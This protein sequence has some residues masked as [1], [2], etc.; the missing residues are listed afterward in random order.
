MPDAPGTLSFNVN[1]TGPGVFTAPAAITAPSVPTAPSVSVLTPVMV[2]FSGTGFGQPGGANFQIWGALVA[3]N[4]QTYNVTS[5]PLNITIG[6][7]ASWTGN[8]Q[9]T[10]TDTNTSNS[11][12]NMVGTYLLNTQIPS[13]TYAA[14]IIPFISHV[15]DVSV[16][17]TG[18]YGVHAQTTGQNTKM[19]SSINPY[20]TG[21]FTA[22]DKTFEL[23]AGSTLTLTSDYTLG[24]TASLVGFEHQL[25][26]HGP[27]GGESY[28][29]LNNGSTT[30]ILKNSGTINLSSGY[31]LV[32]IM[33]DTEFNRGAEVTSGFHY[34]R[35]K[36]IND[37]SIIIGSAARNSI[38]IDYGYYMSGSPNPE[39]YLGD[40][41]INGES[42][43]GFRMND[44]SLTVPDYYNLTRVYG[45]NG[46]ITVAGQKNIGI[47]LFQGAS[48]NSMTAS[49]ITIDSGHT[50]PGDIFNNLTLTVSGTENV[51]F[52]RRFNNNANALYLSSTTIND[53]KFGSSATNSALIRSDLG[54]II[55]TK[56]LTLTAG[57]LRNTGLQAGG[58]GTVTLASGTTMTSSLPTFYGMTA[59]NFSGSTGATAKNLGTLSLSGANSIGMAIANGNTGTSSGN[60]TVS[61]ASST[62]VYNLGNMTITNGTITASGANS[63]A[64]YHGGGSTSITGTNIVANGKSTTGIFNNANGLTISG[65]TINA[66]GTSAGVSAGVYNPLGRTISLSI[67]ITANAYATGLYN[68]GT[69]TIGNTITAAGS[70]SSTG[71]Y[72]TGTLT[73]NS[74]I[75]VTGKGTGL[76][77]GGGSLSGTGSISVSGNGSAG[78]YN[79]ASLGT[80]GLGITVTGGSS[81][82]V[83]NDST[84]TTL[85]GNITVSGTVG[86]V[87]VG[88]RNNSGKTIGTLSGTISAA[89]YATAIHNAG[90]MN[91][92]GT[93]N[94]TGTSQSTG[95][96]NT[97]AGNLT[98]GSGLTIGVTG[99]D[100]T[101]IYNDSSNALT[102][103]GGTITVSGNSS[104]G[105]YHASTAASGT[106]TMTGGAITTTGDS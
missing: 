85:N 32:G 95:I 1:P 9:V 6:N 54:E 10:R 51:G 35:P 33:I 36:T 104:A 22:T 21:L 45:N 47:A 100:G 79:G 26:A 42:N 80:M 37:G 19:F 57:G 12:G 78:F 31:N 97:G 27:G 105:L 20:L 53:F 38:G 68:V 50:D 59:G 84:I 60:I 83:Y 88:V 64:V 66:T 72:N 73:L 61:G 87:S 103:N 3:Q 18:N 39:V 49:S 14:A 99:T 75:N 17:I 89:S 34:K 98:L 43:Y 76:Y 74:A 92:T 90:T 2:T 30:H 77:F 101:G 106:F 70:N 71:I 55:L 16:T 40:I 82:G 56:G 29:N 67:P 48:I 25:L 93:V 69:A 4:F 41:T 24:S 15:E 8:M 58:T 52:Y 44:Y 81:I 5:S 28:G 63:T 86:N 23:T 62:G 65:G 91:V 11:V 7:S 102:L 13:Q 94:A 96:Y 46:T